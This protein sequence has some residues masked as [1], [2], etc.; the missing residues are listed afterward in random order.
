VLFLRSS[1]NVPD[2]QEADN[3]LIGIPPEARRIEEL[4]GRQGEWQQIRYVGQEGY[5][6]SRY[7]A[8]DTI[9]CPDAYPTRT[10]QQDP[11]RKSGLAHVKAPPQSQEVKVGNGT[12][13]KIPFPVTPPTVPSSAVPATT[14]SIQAVAPISAAP[15]GLHTTVEDGYRVEEGFFNVTIGRQSNAATGPVSRKLTQW[16]SCLSCSTR[17]A[18]RSQWRC[19]KR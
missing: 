15:S 17:T 11:T 9:D 3:R 12:G 5:A 1:P 8:P 2:P 16:A 10:D 7:L 19:A 13:N 14:A 6:N 18:V 4:G